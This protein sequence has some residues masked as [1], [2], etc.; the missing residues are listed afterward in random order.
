MI[1]GKNPSILE[2]WCGAGAGVGLN[3][4]DER[5]ASSR[6]RKSP[7][8]VAIM[9]AIF[10]RGCMVITGVFV[11]RMLHVRRRPAVMLPQANRLRELIT[12]GLFSLMGERG[13]TRGWPI[14]T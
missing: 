14:T 6:A 2:N 1:V 12:Y 4:L 5:V 10:S 7:T 3:C 9:A 13:L 8:R 11:G